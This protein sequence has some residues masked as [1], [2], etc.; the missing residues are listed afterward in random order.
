MRNKWLLSG[1]LMLGFHEVCAQA[2]QVSDKRATS[3]T[4][5]LFRKLDKL[6]KQGYLV[7]HQD[8]LA[9]G[10]KWKYQPGRSDIKDI[11][12]DNPALYGWELGHIE[13]DSAVN[14]DTVPF[15]K[16][17]K[18][19]REGYRRGGVIT[20]SWHGDNPLTGKSAWDPAP[21]TVRAILPG[22][23]RHDVFVKQLDKV[24]A[25]LGDLKGNKGEAIPILFRPFH[26]L[27]GG[28][29]WWGTNSSTP[30]EF[31]ELFRFTINYLR[32]KKHLHNLI[33]VYNTGGGFKDEQ[34]YFQRYPGDDVVDVVSFDTYQLGKE[35]LQRPFIDMLKNNLT[36]IE[37]VGQKRKK[38]PAIGEIGFNNVP[39]EAWFTKVLA[40][41]IQGHKI[42]YVLLWRNAGFKAD[43][44]S[45]EY[46][47]PF[48]G[49]RSEKD[50]LKFYYLP[51]TLFE[52]D[53]AALR[54]YN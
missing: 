16:M 52:K 4:I 35:G 15:I 21:G 3:K 24:A 31:K 1:L 9:Y 47:V 43:D 49:D 39:Y 54:L 27:T 18:F 44:K 13:L 30:Q 5:A 48:K 10:V 8:A 45:V 32:D 23:S 36:I 37:R 51:Q 6:K 34:E 29:F 25:F 28:W 26:E 19:I 46:Y 41:S 14:L 53:A 33:I 42:A 7:G 20:I 38:I 11:T 2:L 22:G 17:K 50:F 12:G 40:T